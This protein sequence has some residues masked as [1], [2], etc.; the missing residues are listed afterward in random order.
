M[1]NMLLKVGSVGIEA[2]KV[3]VGISPVDVAKSGE[4][5]AGEIDQIAAAHPAYSDARDVQNVARRS[6]PTPQHVTRNNG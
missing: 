4:V 2:R 1:I 6:K 3:F 5:L